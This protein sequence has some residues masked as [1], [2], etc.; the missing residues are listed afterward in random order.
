[1][2][3]VH[4]AAEFVFAVKPFWLIRAEATVRLLAGWPVN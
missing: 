2:Y 3:A 1:M 4:V